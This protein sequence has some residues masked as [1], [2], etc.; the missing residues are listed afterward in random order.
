MVMDPAPWGRLQV[1]WGLLP[2]TGAQVRLREGGGESPGPRAGPGC[3]QGG[4]VWWAQAGGRPPPLQA[5][6]KVRDTLFWRSFRL[7]SRGLGRPELT[8]ALLRASEAKAG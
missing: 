1:L 5:G 6:Q 8:T 2:T 7:G 3:P 4:Q